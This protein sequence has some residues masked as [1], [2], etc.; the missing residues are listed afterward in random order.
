MQAVSSRP[1]GENAI[2][3]TACTSTPVTDDVR[4]TATGTVSHPTVGEAEG[5]KEGVDVM[6]PVLLAVG[7]A[8]TDAL[9]LSEGVCVFVLLTVAPMLTD[10][11]AVMVMEAV[12]LAE[13]EGEAVRLGVMVA[14]GL[15]L[16]CG[17]LT[18]SVCW[19]TAV[20]DSVKVCSTSLYALRSW[21][22]ASAICRAIVASLARCL[23][24]H[25]TRLM[26]YTPPRSTS[27]E[28][29]KERRYFT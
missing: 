29:G 4:R 11:L 23:F 26:L 6:E 12:R 18:T 16:N 3:S 13:V 19:L 10:R 28:G 5:V 1:V 24:H 7:L 15:R 27:C 25:M 22:V 14:V 8:D 17:R 20:E 2:T 21:T 9:L